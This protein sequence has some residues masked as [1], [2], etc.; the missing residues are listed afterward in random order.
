M[1]S[2]SLTSHL[3]YSRKQKSLGL[4]CTNFLKL[5][6]REGIE[7]VGLDEAAVQLGVERRRIY[8]IVNVLESVGVLSRKAKNRYSWKGIDSIP[9]ALEELKKEALKENCENLPVTSYDCQGDSIENCEDEKPSDLSG[10]ETSQENSTLGSVPS[11]DS[12]FCSLS[13]KGKTDHRRE[14]S[15]G[16]LTRNFVK[17]FLTTNADTVSLDEA[18]MLLLC[19]PGST[20]MRNNSAAKVRRLYDIANVLSS[21][22]LIEKTHQNETKKPAFRWLGFN[23]KPDD[24]ATVSPKSSN[25]EQSKKREFGSDITNLEFTKR[26]RLI[27]LVDDKPIKAQMKHEDPSSQRH[28]NQM[29][30]HQHQQ[31]Q[32]QANSKGYVFGPFQPVLQDT[33]KK[34]LRSAR[35]LEAFA[36]SYR[37]QYHNQGNI[38]TTPLQQ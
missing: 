36:S 11:G 21:M 35:D 19:D 12:S 34:S 8:D 23:G 30:E 31:Q 18:A 17:L 27:S 14:K 13:S 10:G 5:Y 16:L 6:D 32:Q 7:S 29:L 3:T 22:N 33:E 25:F 4:L 38:L 24:D 26:S 20:M 28:L 15:L 2:S 9:Q 37:P 1:A